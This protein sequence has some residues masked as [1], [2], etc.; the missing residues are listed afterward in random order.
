MVGVGRV[1]A[2]LPSKNHSLPFQNFKTFK[3]FAYIGKQVVLSPDA[4]SSEEVSFS[5]LPRK[6]LRTQD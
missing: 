6:G 4:Q 5:L 1:T 3:K 2:L